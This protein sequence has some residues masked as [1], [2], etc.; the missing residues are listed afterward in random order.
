MTYNPAR[1]ASRWE[2]PPALL[3]RLYLLVA[4]LLAVNAALTGSLLVAD[5]VSDAAS[6]I[7]PV[8]LDGGYHASGIEQTPH[9]S[10][11]EH[12]LGHTAARG[13]P[14]EPTSFG[15]I[16]P[17]AGRQLPGARTGSS[18]EHTLAEPL[19]GGEPLRELLGRPPPA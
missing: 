17:Q 11:A 10:E 2:T 7:A 14:E 9:F 6:E 5:D 16:P 18:R 8:L 3:A 1:T 19:T 4:A 12:L 15:V 13:D